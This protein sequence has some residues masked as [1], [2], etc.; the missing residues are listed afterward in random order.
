VVAATG[1]IL[2]TL[3]VSPRESMIGLAIIFLGIPVFWLWESRA[4]R[5]A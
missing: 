5:K 3:W 2:N 1:I 4:V